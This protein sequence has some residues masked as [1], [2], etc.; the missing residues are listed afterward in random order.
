MQHLLL[1]FIPQVA[2]ISPPSPDIMSISTRVLQMMGRSK[3]SVHSLPF[4]HKLTRGSAVLF[5]RCIE[6]HC[7]IWPIPG[8]I[9][10]ISFTLGLGFIL[11]FQPVVREW[12]VN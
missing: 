7:L 3:I 12:L 1:H 11:H 5:Y 6:V 9:N 4:V 2:A 10:G 8:K